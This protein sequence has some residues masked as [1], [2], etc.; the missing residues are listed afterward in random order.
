MPMQ[1]LWR[2]TGPVS[3]DLLAVM[4]RNLLAGPLN[5]QVRFARVPLARPIWSPSTQANPVRVSPVALRATEI[6]D[7]A[8]DAAAVD[9]DVVGGRGWELT[10]AAVDDGT[11]IVSL[12][13][14]H[15]LTDGQGLLAA[16]LLAAHNEYPVALGAVGRPTI[17]ADVMDA[18]HGGIRDHGRLVILWAKAFR[19]A[20]RKRGNA[21]APM[22]TDDRSESV[23]V[24]ST[25]AVQ[26]DTNAIDRI[27]AMHGGTA[28]SLMLAITANVARRVRGEV[29]AGDALS[30][31]V[32]VSLRVPGDQALSNVMAIATVVFEVQD[33]RYTDLADVRQ[34][35][36]LAY[37]RVSARDTGLAHSDAGYSTVGVLP[38]EVREAFGPALGVIGRATSDSGLRPGHV[39][40]FTGWGD[41]TTSLWFQA[42]GIQL[43]RS[44]V[45]DEFDAWGL[46]VI[47]WW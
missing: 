35:S 26:V 22:G 3:H 1:L 33:A 40:A 16:L 23:P 28:T 12:V 36:K 42:T 19:A 13:C 24:R 47:R 17:T 8:D 38:A 34:R 45:T 29:G 5:R 20:H 43:D 10:A 2:V 15:A 44:I 14:S 41:G 27:A 25:V 30:V 31:A 21:L 37:A 4:H 39:F 6:L 11:S 46:A 7:W 18:V 9:L 32:P